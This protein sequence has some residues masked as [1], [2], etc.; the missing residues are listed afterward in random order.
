VRLEGL[1][2][3]KKSNNLIGIRT[4][5]LPACSIVPQP[6]TLPRA[7]IDTSRMINPRGM[8]WTEHILVVRMGEM[9]NA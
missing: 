6:S 3:L 4:R 5:D 9:I 2:Q 8:K 1:S 7:Q